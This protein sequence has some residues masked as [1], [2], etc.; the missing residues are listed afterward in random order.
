VANWADL[1]LQQFGQQLGAGKAV[2]RSAQKWPEV[3][4]SAPL[5]STVLRSTDSLPGLSSAQF[6]SAQLGQTGTSLD[7]R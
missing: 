6:S 4:R 3:E 2:E 1:A 7:E 5:E